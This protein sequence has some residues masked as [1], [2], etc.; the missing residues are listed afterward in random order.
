MSG[1]VNSTDVYVHASDTE[2][3]NTVWRGLM[4]RVRDGFTG[5]LTLHCNGGQVMKVE[6]REFTRVRDVPT[7][8]RARTQ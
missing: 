5:Q 4:D 7:P 3:F 8:T 2:A 1:E 6:T